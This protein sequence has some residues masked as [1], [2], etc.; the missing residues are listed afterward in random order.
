MRRCMLQAL[1]LPDI[2]HRGKLLAYRLLCNM[3]L[4]SH[5]MPLPPGLL[6]QF[7][8]VVHS[9]LTSSDQVSHL[10]EII[11]ISTYCL[12]ESTPVG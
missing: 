3:V 5:D 8:K 10:V 4:A 2:Y 11:I 12:K 9:A 1:T 7:Y 6:T